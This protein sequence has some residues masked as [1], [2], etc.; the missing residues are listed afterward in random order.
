MHTRRDCAPATTQERNTT[1]HEHTH[2]LSRHLLEC[3]PHTSAHQFP[4]RRGRCISA[5]T[6][7]RFS[8]MLRSRYDAPKRCKYDSP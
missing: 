2:A 5:L 8:V 1:T 6:T 4:S 7:S 3:T